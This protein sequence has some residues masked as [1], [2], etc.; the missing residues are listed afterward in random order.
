M[1]EQGRK[2]LDNDQFDDFVTNVLTKKF[3]Y[4]K[5]NATITIIV[6]GTLYSK[7]NQEVNKK[8]WLAALR[9]DQPVFAEEEESDFAFASSPEL[10]LQVFALK[11]TQLNEDNWT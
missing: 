1:V 9:D 4:E 5:T 7:E 3:N 6:G 10:A 11:G 8:E 2:F